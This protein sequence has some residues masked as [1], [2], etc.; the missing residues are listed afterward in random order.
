MIQKDEA[1]KVKTCR[2]L[3]SFGALQ[4]SIHASLFSVFQAEPSQ[5]LAPDVGIEASPVRRRGRPT[6]AAAAAA[7]AALKEAGTLPAGGGAGRGRKRAA[8]ATTD[9]I[10]VKMSKQQ[11]LQQSDEGTKRQIDLQR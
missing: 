9:S 2:N 1:K 8:D 7:A 3:D 5:K 11:Q 4:H 10:N 6:K